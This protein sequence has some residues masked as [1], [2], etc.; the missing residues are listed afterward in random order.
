MPLMKFA[1]IQLSGCAGC[2]VSLLNAGEWVDRYKLVYI[3]LA[4]SA[5]D[6]PEVDVLSEK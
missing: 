1:V 5:Y 4:I 6:V 3:L 2:E